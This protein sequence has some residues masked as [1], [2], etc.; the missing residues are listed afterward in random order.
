MQAFTGKS[1][2]FAGVLGAVGL[3]PIQVRYRA[4]LRPVSNTIKMAKQTGEYSRS[5]TALQPNGQPEGNLLSR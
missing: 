2:C 5:R 1:C 4:A 3:H